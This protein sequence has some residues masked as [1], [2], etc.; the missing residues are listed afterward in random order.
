M[1]EMEKYSKSE[2]GFE[3]PAQGQQTCAGCSHFEVDAPLH[4]EIVAGR[5]LP[6]DWCRKYKAKTQEK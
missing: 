4:C 5:I 6:G 1:V 3:H 2:V